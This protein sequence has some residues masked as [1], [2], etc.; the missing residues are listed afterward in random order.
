MLVELGDVG[1]DG[2]ECIVCES[3]DVERDEESIV[4]V[5]YKKKVGFAVE[6]AGSRRQCVVVGE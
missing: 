4:F 3:G 5:L 1:D 2:S 6:Y